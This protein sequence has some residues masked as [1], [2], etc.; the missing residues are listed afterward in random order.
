MTTP[1]HTGHCCSLIL[2][3]NIVLEE[4]NYSEVALVGDLW[5]E[6]NDSSFWPDLSENPEIQSETR[7]KLVYLWPD[8]LI[9]PGHG[10]PF[11][12]SDYD[13]HDDL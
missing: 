10:A 6:K 3:G 5:D 1:G 12:A 4:K 7:R 9:I 11:L 13:Y 2:T 8:S